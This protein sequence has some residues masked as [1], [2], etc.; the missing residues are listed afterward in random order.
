MV[1]YLTN[2]S[3]NTK[4]NHKT[5]LDEFQNLKYAPTLTLGSVPVPSSFP[6]NAS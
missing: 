2:T 3:V 1:V 5:T 4:A 6:V